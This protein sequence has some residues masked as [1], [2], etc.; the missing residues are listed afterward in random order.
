M[1]GHAV[2][3]IGV[4]VLLTLW[5]RKRA[6]DGRPLTC[7]QIHYGLSERAETVG[8]HVVSYSAVKKAVRRLL[9]GEDRLLSGHPV[10]REFGHRGPGPMG[11]AI[12]SGKMMTYPCTARIALELFNYPSHDGAEVERFKDRVLDLHLVNDE[13]KEP[14]TRKDIDDQMAYCMERGYIVGDEA[15][16]RVRATDRVNAQRLFLERI[17][18]HAQTKKAAGSER[19]SQTASASERNTGVS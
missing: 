12:A 10:P 4:M 6:G 7:R 5:E 16:G 17:A 11:F 14:M 9:Q 13:N 15:P 8:E 18:L 19:N 3:E 1:S 2:D